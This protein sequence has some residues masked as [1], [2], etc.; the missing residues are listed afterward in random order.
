MSLRTPLGRARGLGS[1][2]EGSSHW[3]SQRLTSLALVP[4]VLWFVFSVALMTGADHV[5]FLEWVQSPI[6]AGLLILL[7]SVG[8]L[9]SQQGMQVVIEDYVH[10]EASKVLSLFLSLSIHVV[11]GLTGIL[12]IL[13]I[14]FRG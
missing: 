11:L 5:Q 8:L 4:L 3:W 9:H 1:A 6:V 13:M 10:G 14:L 2:K 7:I 12:S